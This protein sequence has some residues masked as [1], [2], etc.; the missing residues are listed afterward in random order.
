MNTVL[1]IKSQAELHP[2]GG[3]VDLECL[4]RHIRRLATLE[5]SESPIISCYVDLSGS[6]D[7]R[8]AL[9]SRAHPIRQTLEPTDGRAFEVAF[10]GIVQFL[11]TGL[12][13]ASRGAAAFYRGGSKPL[14][15]ALQFGI[16]VPTWFSLGMTPHIGHLVELK[17]TYDRYVVVILGEQRSRILE[18]SL[19]AVTREVWSER[20]EL[21][22]RVGSE[23]ARGR[24]Q[25]HHRGRD[26]PLLKE[27]LRILEGLIASGGHTHI[28]LAGTP[29]MTAS[30]REALPRHL[31]AKVFDIV[32]VT[33]HTQTAEV[34]AATLAR[35]VEQ[36]ERESLG[37]VELL[38][39]ELRR[40]GLAVAGVRP[41][42]QALHRRQVDV[43]LM[44]AE[45][46][47]PTG[48]ACEACDGLEGAAERPRACPMC[49][50]HEL[51]TVDLKEEMIRL[52]EQSGSHVE[53]VR[54]S[55]M[56]RAFA[57]VGGLLRYQ[58]PQTAPGGQSTRG[59]AD[60]NSDVMRREEGR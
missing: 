24:Y 29:R 52:A 1:G 58:S 55:G 5:E 12:L 26:T 57:G 7:F 42:V 21:R 39:R 44:A 60:G 6:A 45:F 17:D 10:D 19:G 25:N 22:Q 16:P 34:V 50:G 49:G 28:V 9:D 59:G 30:V 15:L 35:F 40:G 23:W 36:E 43:L 54:D 38:I 11:G 56:L 32:P 3:I 14:S 46:V 48:W 8:A 53:F 37:M 2:Q 27:E 20:P 47:W 18:I 13:P 41:I 31:A 33:P 51:R 4:R